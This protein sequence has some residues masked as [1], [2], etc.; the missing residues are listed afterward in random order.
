MAL[1]LAALDALADH[2]KLEPPPKLLEEATQEEMKALRLKP[3]LRGE[4]EQTVRRR[5][6]REILA[7][8]VAEQKGLLPSEDELKEEAEKLGVEPDQMWGRL[9]FSRAADWII[10]H[11][12]RGK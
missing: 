6:R 12:R 1:R 4:V 2:L 3:E 7:Q 9:V 5:L 8:R 10:E 11:A